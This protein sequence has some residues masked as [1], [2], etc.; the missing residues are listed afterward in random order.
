MPYL[1][2]SIFVLLTFNKYS[3][4]TKVFYFDVFQDFKQ[5]SCI[6]ICDDTDGPGASCGDLNFNT[7]ISTH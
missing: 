1:Q 4:S 5:A 6:K 3:Q 2:L 7:I